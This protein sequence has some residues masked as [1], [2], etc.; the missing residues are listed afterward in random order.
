MKNF[1]VKR[2]EDPEW[3]AYMAVLHV[4]FKDK[5][6]NT[7]AIAERA[8]YVGVINGLLRVQSNQLPDVELIGI[9][10]AIRLLS[11]KVNETR[12][13]VEKPATA[14]KKTEP[15]YFGV[16]NMPAWFAESK[17]NDEYEFSNDPNF[18]L[19]DSS[20]VRFNDFI[21]T[22]RSSFVVYDMLEGEF[23][24]YRYA[25]KH[26]SMESQIRAAIESYNEKKIDEPLRLWRAMQEIE[27]KFKTKPQT[28]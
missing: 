2:I 20:V 13:E 28:P 5:A 23:L 24:G 7:L 19:G 1:Q 14:E 21:G 15:E 16:D 9:P 22:H 27:Y 8:N 11:G 18:R 12:N 4:M 25:R 3:G 6:D 17:E 10:E 26:T